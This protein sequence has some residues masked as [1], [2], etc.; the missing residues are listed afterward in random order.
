MLKRTLG[1]DRTRE[2]GGFNSGPMRSGM[3]IKMRRIGRSN[4]FSTLV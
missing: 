3:W 2:H 4:S 1:R